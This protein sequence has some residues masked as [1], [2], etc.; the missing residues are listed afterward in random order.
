MAF[1]YKSNGL[2]VREKPRNGKRFTLGELQSF[3]G[4][5]IEHVPCKGAVYCNESG[6]IDNLPINNNATNEALKRGWIRCLP[7]E[8]LNGD[9]VFLEPVEGS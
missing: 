8:V 5:A 9:V 3:V 1:V 7:G 6:K 2:I 4:G